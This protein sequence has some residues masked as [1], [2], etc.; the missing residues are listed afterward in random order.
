M[1][2]I[3]PIVISLVTEVLKKLPFVPLNE[4]NKLAIQGVTVALSVGAVIG[5]AYLAGALA[6]ASTVD[7]I[8][9][10]ISNYLL[11]V[12]AYHGFIKR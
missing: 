10:S 2:I 7:I 6:D 5:Q 3:Q 11:A 12:L 9:A 8:S 1:Q 4:K